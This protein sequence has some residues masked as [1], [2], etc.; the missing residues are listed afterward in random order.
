M[1]TFRLIARLDIRNARLIKTVRCEG[2]RPVGDPAEYAKRYDKEGIDE[3]LYLDAVA[4]LYGRN[5]LADLLDK[6]T[7]EVFT[8]VT[9]GGG[10]RSVGD[11]QNLLRAGADKIALNTAA[12]KRPELITELAMKFGSQ[13]VVVQI[14][15]KRKG[16]GWEAY[17]D[18]GRQ[19]TGRDAIAWAKEVISRG[20]GELLVTSIDQ[21]G[22]GQG[23]DS[24]LGIALDVA[25]PV[26]LSGGFGCPAHAVE[27]AQAGVSGIA[28]TGALHYN[29][30]SLKEIRW[31]LHNASIPVRLAA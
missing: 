12:I 3:I 31:A 16:N 9:A 28:I 5:G 6:T 7:N 22:T 1:L 18:G 15:A 26:V 17:C 11:A 8:P 27:A 20:A 21:E 13:A 10:V 25:A 14:D 4:S 24:A 23:F 19:A 29:R 30:V 2:V